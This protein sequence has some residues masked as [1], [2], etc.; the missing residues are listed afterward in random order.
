MFKRHVKAATLAAL[1][2]LSTAATGGC[3]STGRIIKSLPKSSQP[4]LS[5]Y[6]ALEDVMKS[7]Y[8]VKVVAEYVIMHPSGSEPPSD[9]KVVGSVVQMGSAFA[10]SSD[11]EYTYLITASHVVETDEVYVDPLY[12]VTKRKSVSMKLVDNKLDENEQDDVPVE[13]SL[14]VADRDFAVLRTKSKLYVSHKYE[15]ADQKS[16]KVGE[17]AFTAGYPLS[18]MKVLSSGTIA[19][20]TVTPNKTNPEVG[21]MFVVDVDVMAGSSGGPLFVRRGDKLY[22][23][24]IVTKHL[25]FMAA[26]VGT[27]CIE[28]YLS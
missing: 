13:V 15:V 23:A 16:L 9:N 12:G 22:F 18:L 6:D 27:A 7:V 17:Q 8:C 26:A 10:F 5:Q 14:N 2:G 19:N 20:T 4:Q 3:G 21:C 1:V 24:G 11:N 28:D 25:A